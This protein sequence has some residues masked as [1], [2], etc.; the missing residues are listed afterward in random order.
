[1]AEALESSMAWVRRGWQM[2]TQYP[3]TWIALTGIWFLTALVLVFVPM[4][5]ILWWL[6]GPA[7]YAGFIFAAA[8]IEAGRAPQVGH[9]FQGF[10]DS[11]KRWAFISLGALTMLG[12]LV[13]SLVL[14][15]ITGNEVAPTVQIGTEVVNTGFPWAFAISVALRLLLTLIV[16]VLLTSG[17]M[18]SAPLVMFRHLE[19]IEAMMTSA[20]AVWEHWQSLALLT[21][22]YVLAAG[23][24][25]LIFVLPKLAFVP[26]LIGTV[27]MAIGVLVLAPVTL[28]AT[29][30]AYK[31]LLGHT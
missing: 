1:M 21:L 19:G 3:S 13:M 2:F 28:C 16:T 14:A 7:V 4:G 15:S 6:I 27:L 20:E 23:L 9:L 10:K 12:Y 8:E 22:I 24:A 30:I 29:Y 11:D 5:G 25:F 17:L 31:T 26:F 18:F